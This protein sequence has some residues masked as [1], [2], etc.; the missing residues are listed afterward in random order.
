MSA[1]SLSIFFLVLF[2]RADARLGDRSSRTHRDL[3]GKIPDILTEFK[4]VQPKPDLPAG[5]GGSPSA[6]SS[7]SSSSSSNAGRVTGTT[8]PPPAPYTVSSSV[9]SEQ[10]SAGTLAPA[11]EESLED[12]VIY[13]AVEAPETEEEVN[14]EGDNSD[15]NEEDSNG[16]G[17]KHDGSFYNGKFP[18]IAAAFSPINP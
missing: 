9:F 6:S 15:E 5:G 2:L 13:A 11:D 18:D 10:A 1:F 16:G 8:P 17:S 14:D 3:A 7:S 4:P 12:V